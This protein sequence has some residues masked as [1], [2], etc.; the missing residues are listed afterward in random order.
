VSDFAYIII[1]EQQRTNVFKIYGPKAQLY[2]RVLR[3]FY[4]SGCVC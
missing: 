4:K 1:N 3:C 2:K